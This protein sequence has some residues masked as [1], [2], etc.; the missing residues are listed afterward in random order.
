MKI[1]I[2][3]AAYIYFSL[4]S[5][6][7]EFAVKNLI[8][9]SLSGLDVTPFNFSE[10]GEGDASAPTER[11]GYDLDRT[12]PKIRIAFDCK[13]PK[14]YILKY[15]TDSNASIIF[16]G[17]PDSFTERDLIIDPRWRGISPDE[18]NRI[19]S[20]IMMTIEVIRSALFIAIKNGEVQIFGRNANDKLVYID[21]KIFELSLSDY[22]EME[23]PRS[24]KFYL[25]WTE[26]V[27]RTSDGF[28]S[29]VSVKMEG[30]KANTGIRPEMPRLNKVPINLINKKEVMSLR[31]EIDKIISEEDGDKK[32]NA[33]IIY[34]LAKK[35]PDISKSAINKELHERVRLLLGSNPLNN[36]SKPGRRRVEPNKQ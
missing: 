21:R 1:S 11:F 23:N 7:S 9:I 4:G 19:N 24:E 15:A 26:G 16:D 34:E 25:N 27:L 17:I 2:S 8:P 35:F 14:L 33:D 31:A 12:S 5:K 28:W 6:I 30:K 13:I 10:R 22:I 29:D 36:W 18:L 20:I 32:K 3:S